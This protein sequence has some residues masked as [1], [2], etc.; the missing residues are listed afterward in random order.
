MRRNTEKVI[1][2]ALYSDC[3]RKHG[4][5]IT[6]SSRIKAVGFN[7]SL[8]T[9]FL[10]KVD[11]CMHAEMAALT[12]YINGTYRRCSVQKRTRKLNKL[13]VWSVRTVAGRLSN[14]LPCQICLYRLKQ[15]GIGKIA[16]S[17]SEGNIV[18]CLLKNVHNEHLS[19][20]QQRLAGVIRW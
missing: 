3:K 1:E 4:A 7:T 2:S 19:F 10:G 13:T 11:V 16:Y 12:A 18:K 15:V 17:T 14:S 9:S 20:V 6:Q 5:L 8:R